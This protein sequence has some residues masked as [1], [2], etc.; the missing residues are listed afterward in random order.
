MD[1]II[2]YLFMIPAALLSLS[3]HEC[4]HGYAAYRLGDPTARNFGR[5]SLNP[6][7]HFDL[8]GM[9]CMV[10]FRVGWA[11]P[12]PINPRNFKNP[13]NGM[14]ITAAAGPLSNLL[15]A[16]I[17]AIFIKL[18]VLLANTVF[19]YAFGDAIL[20]LGKYALT[21]D[22]S[23]LAYFFYYLILFFELFHFA[24]LSLFVFNML[25][26]PPF[27]GSRIFFIFLPPRLYFK[28]MK[29]EHIIQIV[30]IVAIA[31]GALTGVLST[32][33]G[34]VSNGIFRILSFIP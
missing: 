27:D 10:F 11:K 19:P 30:I 4:C 18:I 26:I 29:Y 6:L 31:L 2:Q 25:P 1:T 8:Y 28:I 34:W 20:L 5:L 21:A 33:T 14:A 15:L 16:F 3:V 13:R 32:V 17:A 9:L 12:V 23:Y 24:N 7:K 22:A